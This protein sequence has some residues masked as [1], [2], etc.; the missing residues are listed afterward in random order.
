VRERERDFSAHSCHTVTHPRF[1]A[2][3]VIADL[4]A[5]RGYQ[6]RFAFIHTVAPESLGRAGFPTTT[7]LEVMAV[8]VRNWPETGFP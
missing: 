1:F 7:P 8:E 3:G 6:G 2:S 4:E 5:L